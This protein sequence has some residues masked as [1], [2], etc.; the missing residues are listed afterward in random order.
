MTELEDI[1]QKKP[2]LNLTLK[3]YKCRLYRL[4]EEQYRSLRLNSLPISS[5]AFVLLAIHQKYQATNEHLTLP[6]FYF[7]LTRIAGE[8]SRFYDDWKGTFC[9]PFLMKI[10]KPESVLDN[11]LLILADWR[12][13]LE[14]RFRR[15]IGENEHYVGIERDVVRKPFEDEF[16]KKEMDS[17]IVYFY[18]YLVGFFEGCSET[19]QKLVLPHYDLVKDDYE[20]FKHIDS[21]SILYGYT[22]GEFWEKHYEEP[23]YYC[24]RRDEL[25]LKYPG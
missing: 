6:K 2:N 4:D 9:F 5:N 15:L 1:F 17:F 10:D 18:S 13:N 21:N 14:F 24:Q 25:K 23:D 7:T 11:Y 20:F 12:G 16:S 8:S 19:I 22:D 3:D